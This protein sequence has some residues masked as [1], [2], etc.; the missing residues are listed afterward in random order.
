ME[1]IR[2]YIRKIEKKERKANLKTEDEE[3]EKGN[4]ISD[5]ELVSKKC[6][7]RRGEAKLNTR[8]CYSKAYQAA[9]R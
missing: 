8:T 3:G 6:G 7:R 1:G 4:R 9:N 2:G 5:V